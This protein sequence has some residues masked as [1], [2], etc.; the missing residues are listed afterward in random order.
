MSALLEDLPVGVLVV[1]FRGIIKEANLEMSRI[2]LHT[3]LVGQPFLSLIHH[4]QRAKYNREFLLAEGLPNPSQHLGKERLFKLLRAD[5]TL[6]E[7]SLRDSRQSYGFLLAISD[8]TEARKFALAEQRWLDLSNEMPCT[9]DLKAQ[10]FKYLSPNWAKETGWSYDELRAS[11]V[12]TFLH[13]DGRLAFQLELQALGDLSYQVLGLQ[14]RFLCKDDGWLFL[15]WNMTSDGYFAYASAKKIRPLRNR[16]DEIAL[17]S[18]WTSG[19]QVTVPIEGDL[20]TKRFASVTPE[21]E[22]ALGWSQEELCQW[23]IVEFIHPDD[24]LDTASANATLQ[25]TGLLLKFTNR[26][27]HKDCRPN[28][29]TRWIWL[30]WR[31][32][33]HEK[34]GTIFASA[35][36]VTAHKEREIILDGVVQEL[37]AANLDLEAFASAAAHQLKSPPRSIAGLAR[38]LVEDYGDSFNQDTLESLEMITSDAIKLGEVVE[39]LHQFSS[40]RAA[41]PGDLEM[42]SLSALLQNLYE[43]KQRRHYWKTA[44]MTWPKSLPHVKVYP[45]LFYEVLSNLVDNAYKYNINEPRILTWKWHHHSTDASRICLGLQDN[46]IGIEQKVIENK[47]FQLFQR[48]HPTFPAKGHGVGLAMCKY[49]MDKMGESI[50]AESEGPGKGSTFWLTL[51]LHQERDACPQDSVSHRS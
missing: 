41:E 46:G 13:P 23:S 44:Q 22:E 3:N 17:F 19:L 28:G 7:C 48:V 38:A 34:S 33:C 37:K 10:R 51:S 12:S 15:Q 16:T 26:Y 40:L 8:Y 43:H 18:R 36:D 20:Q 49:V 1:D 24:L 30:E 25:E 11:D 6:I 5:H 32:F 2:S 47:L 29:T 14:A 31:A 35:W 50:W 39:A 42:I 21:W 9:L 4:S 27:R 45:A